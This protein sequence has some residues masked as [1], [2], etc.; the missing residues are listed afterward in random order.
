LL[1]LSSFIVLSGCDSVKR[2]D[3][4][5]KPVETR[6]IAPSDPKPLLL[7]NLHFDVVNKD[8]LE[9]YL[10]ELRKQQNTEEYVFYAISPKTYELLA[11]NM[12]EIKRFIIQQKEIIV[13]YKKATGPKEEGGKK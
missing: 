12:Q 8:N 13:Y 10:V 2:L 6:V 9:E 3:V 5:S 7:D 4:F 1:L 11:L